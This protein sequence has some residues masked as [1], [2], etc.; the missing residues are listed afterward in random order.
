[1]TPPDMQQNTPFYSNYLIQ[2]TK[3]SNFIMKTMKKIFA[4]TLALMLVFSLALTANAAAMTNTGTVK[5]SNAAA[6]ETYTFYRVYDLESVKVDTDK[7]SPIYITNTTWGAF[8]VNDYMTITTDG[9]VT[10]KA[11]LTEADAQ[12]IAA[13]VVAENNT[14]DKTIPA[15]ASGIL[16][17]TGLQYGYYVMKSDRT[18]EDPRY[19]VFTLSSDTVLEITEK[20]ESDLPEFE[21]TVQEDSDSEFGASNTADVGEEITFKLTVTAA[22]GTDTYQIVDT[23]TNLE[24]LGVTGVTLNGTTITEGFTVTP[25]AS[26]STFTVTFT[27]A[28]RKTLKDNDKIEI[29]YTA[30]LTEAA[31]T[32]GV[33]TNEAT[34]TYGQDAE[35]KD[36][37]ETKTYKI[38]VTK[39]DDETGASLDGAVFVLKKGEKFYYYDE[40]DDVVRWV[41][42]QDEATEVTS[43]ADG[44][45][46]FAGI[47]AD[48][49]TLVEIKAPN[50]YVLP[51]ATQDVNV[52]ETTDENGD[53]NVEV[54][55]TN[56]LG[57]ELPE[58]GGM[59]TTLFYTLGGMMVAAAA[60]LLV[61]KKRM[62]AM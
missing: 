32:E 37:T 62:S 38:T 12:T 29:T 57:E 44:V 20:N 4:L 59:G 15:T 61:T 23:L 46:T 45:L 1:M 13:A 58:T 17:I 25:S 28:F 48:D 31:K 54:G 18:N 52:N 2:N 5:I 50:G 21:K 49:Y 10:V 41:D 35:I 22:A 7:V 8:V 26:G 43:G 34:F 19:T 27:D 9:H 24:F 60:V 56:T 3:G 42:S 40:T 14:A 39:T 16:E 47:D 6:G 36:K 55:I 33:G 11:G 51:T 30:K 53:L